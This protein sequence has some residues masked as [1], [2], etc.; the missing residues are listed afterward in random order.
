MKV[1]GDGSPHA[2]SSASE[3]IPDS[4]SRLALPDVHDAT[5][6]DEARRLV[7]QQREQ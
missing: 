2:G 1:G 4:D 7:R 6:V 5:L 3:S